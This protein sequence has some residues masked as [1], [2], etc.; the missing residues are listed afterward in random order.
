MAERRSRE[1][2]TMLEGLCHRTTMLRHLTAKTILVQLH[3]KIET[4]EHIHKRLVLVIQDCLLDYMSR[5]FRFDHLTEPPS[6]GD[7]MFIHA[8]SLQT[9]DSAYRIELSRRLSTDAA[10]IAACLGLQAEAKIDA[11]GIVNSIE[12]RMSDGTLLSIF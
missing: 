3:H 8:Y 6:L 1:C 10:G 7:S 11:A 12:A 9:A 5:E 4:F 2:L